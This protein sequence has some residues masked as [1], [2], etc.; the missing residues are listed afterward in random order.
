M[1][2]S[3]TTFAQTKTAL[4]NRLSD[5]G[6]VYWVDTA[7]NSEIGSYIIEAL[8]TWGLATNYWRN[9]GVIATTANTAFYDITTLTDGNGVALLSRTVTDK[10]ISKLIQYHLLE[11]STGSTWTGSEQFTITDVA[12]SLERRRDLLLSETGAVVTHA[13]QVCPPNSGLVTFANTT[14]QLR[15]LAW[16]GGI[17]AVTW[18][19]L[20]EDINSQRN[21]STSLLNTQGIPLTYSTFSTQPLQALIAPPTN[22][23]GTLD[24]LSINAGTDLDCSGIVLGVPDDMSWI[25]KWGALADM[26]GKEGPAQDLSR[27]YFCE[28]RWRLGMELAKVSATVVN[29]A[30]NGISLNPDA[31][32]NLDLYSPNWQTST[33]APVFVATLRNMAALSPCPDSVYSATFD[34]VCKAIVPTADADYIQVSK[35]HL[36]PII[37]YAE[38]LAAFKCGGM[39]F[40]QTLRGAENFFNVA[41]SYNQKLAAQHPAILELIKQSTRD[42]YVAPLRVPVDNGPLKQL[43]QSAVP[44]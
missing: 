19:I 22:E 30:I 23:P 11:P 34:V 44:Q 9:T 24:I 7:G 15:R 33:A 4:A 6:N 27:S 14:M 12:E 13:T 25:V 21:Y 18:P 32:T 35:E 28:R 1:T 38:H 3:H 8:R 43:V 26:L 36:Q 31:I 42:D 29:A 16:T 17:S 5:T 39:E 40:R 20:P 2:Y 10:D 37:D 41:L